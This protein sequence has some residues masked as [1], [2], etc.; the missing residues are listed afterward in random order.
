MGATSFSWRNVAASTV[1][2]AVTA[3]F[4]AATSGAAALANPVV[5]AMATG[6]VGN[7]SNYAANK[8]A[9][10]DVG[11]SW[12][13]VAASVVSAAITAEVVPALGSA[14]QIDPNSMPGDLLAGITG[15][16]VSAH[17]RQGLVG[18]GVDYSAIAADAF[19]N[20]LANAAGRSSDSSAGLASGGDFSSP[21][22]FAGGGGGP[23]SPYPEDL[24]AQILGGGIPVTDLD[25]VQVSLRRN[26]VTGDWDSAVWNAENR[27]WITS[28]QVMLNGNRSSREQTVEAWSRPPASWTNG[29][30]AGVDA[31]AWQMSRLQPTPQAPKTYTFPGVGLRAGFNSLVDVF[32]AG[33]SIAGAMLSDVGLP[34]T[35]KTLGQTEI[36]QRLVDTATIRLPHFSGT[37]IVRG[38]AGLVPNLRTWAENGYPLPDSSLDMTFGQWKGGINFL[39]DSTEGLANMSQVGVLTHVLTGYRMDLPRFEIPADQ[40]MGAAMF[41]VGMAVVS[42]VAP[43]T[44]VGQA[45]KLSFGEL[46]A[47]RTAGLSR[48]E[49]A[50]TIELNGDI[51]LFRGTSE[52]WGGSPGA[53]ATAVSASVDPYVATVFS[54][55]ARG[56]G[57][58]AILQ[59]GSRSDL[60]TLTRGNWFAVQER[61]VGVLTNSVGFAERAPYTMSVD[62]ARKILNDIGMP[63]LPRIIRTSDDRRIFLDA[64]PKM[65]PEQTREFLRMARDGG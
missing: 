2:G 47:L 12:R 27:R 59:F 28:S 7:L 45:G 35:D 37:G 48:A 64:S 60:G 19:G 46:R 33:S 22:L 61:E 53:Q 1:A 63:P 57:G 17:V 14:L 20:A 52:G 26:A 62:R 29:Y 55:E 32:N 65:T 39:S 38:I 23:G 49:I 13:S 36:G 54:L 51:Y 40:Q 25:P 42:A 16:V 4:G 31:R 30:G 6:A 5:R 50:R 11:F 18:G 24:R 41:D 8:L 43:E 56:Q 58:Q 21:N 15:G 44:R 10:N 3:G 9:G 34:F